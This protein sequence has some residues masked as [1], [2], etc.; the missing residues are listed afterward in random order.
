MNVR[1]LNPPQLHHGFSFRPV[2]FLGAFP[3]QGHMCSGQR[4]GGRADVDPPLLLFGPLI[5][6]IN[7]ASWPDEHLSSDMKNICLG[8]VV[9]LHLKKSPLNAETIIKFY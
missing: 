2:S 8:I 4:G 9:T 5:N 7:V 3:V 6:K 1:P